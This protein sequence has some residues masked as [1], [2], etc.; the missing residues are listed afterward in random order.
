MSLVMSRKNS[1]TK[2]AFWI[3]SCRIIQAILGLVISMISA[4]YLGPSNYGLINYAASIV[5]F[6]LPI[7]QLGFRSTLVQEIIDNPQ[8]EGE[9]LGTSLVFSVISSIFCAFGVCS[10]VYFTSA[11]ETETVIVCAL[12]SLSLIFQATEM[13]Q[14]WF[15]AKLVSHYMSLTGLGAYVL[16]SIYRI[17]LLITEKSIYWF[18][19]SQALD[20]FI[21]SLVLLIIYMKL[22]SQKLTISVKRGLR[23]LDKSKYFIVSSMMVTI[24]A[25]T[26]KIMLKMILGD[27]TVGIYSAAVTCA[28]MSSF[29]FSAIIDSSRPAVFESKKE[30]EEKYQN[31]LK[32]CYSVIIYL[33]LFQSLVFTLMSKLIISVLYGEAY[34]SATNVLRLV[35]WYTTFAYIGPIRNMW[36][37][38]ENKQ[39]YLW[40]INLSG[41][42]VNIILNLVLIPLLG[43]M[44]AALA[45][46]LTQFFTNVL[47]GYIIRPINYNNRLMMQA[48]NPKLFIKYLMLFLTKIRKGKNNV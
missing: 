5:A 14:Y 23:M 7:V 34:S 22:S 26:D 13:I 30:S 11:G 42:V 25:Q 10:F 1:V 3:I 27:E 24:F 33:S 15:Q 46:L 41:A 37:L 43:V 48:L 47:I 12:Y 2:N 17:Y 6:V 28:G 39:R 4:R 29:V 16:V 8:K 38:A 21:I 45:S 18:V 35:V 19:V 36:I 32:K 31:C 9:V 40:I 20:Y 44:G